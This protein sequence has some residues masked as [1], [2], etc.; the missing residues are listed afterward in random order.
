M[1]CRRLWVGS[2]HGT[3]WKA[4]ATALFW[5]RNRFW[6]NRISACNRRVVLLADEISSA[7]TSAGS[8]GA[9]FQVGAG[10]FSRMSTRNRAWLFFAPVVALAAVSVAAAQSGV[11][12]LATYDKGG[13]SYF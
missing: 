10:R 13:E 7:G 3:D 11:A 1:P 9:L 2:R 12:R 8:R 5:W 6:A 4:V